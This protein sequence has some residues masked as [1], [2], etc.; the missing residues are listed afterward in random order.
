MSFLSVQVQYAEKAAQRGQPAVGLSNGKDA[1]V[2]CV[3]RAR[4][5]MLQDL[6]TSEKI[7]AVTVRPTS[8]VHVSVLCDMRL[9][10]R[11]FFLHVP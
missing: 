6:V 11:L 3:E 8:L 9:H 5:S 7:S 2:L 4:A 1:A 10:R